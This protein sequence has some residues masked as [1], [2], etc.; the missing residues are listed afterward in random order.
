M[1]ALAFITAASI[2][3]ASTVVQPYAV[4]WRSASELLQSVLVP[5]ELTELIAADTI[6]TDRASMALVGVIERSLT[7]A[8]I[9]AMKRLMHCTK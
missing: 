4:E 9:V 1:V 3:V 5:P 7:A 8:P 2:V 6:P